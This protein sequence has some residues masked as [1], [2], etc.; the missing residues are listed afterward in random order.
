MNIEDL[1]P[2]TR[3]HHSA[4]YHDVSIMKTVVASGKCTQPRCKCVMYDFDISLMQDR[5]Q[6]ELTETL[7]A[8][9][10]DILKEREKSWGN[11]EETHARIAKI[12]SG[13]LDTEVTAYQVALCM[14][15]MKLVR[16]EKNP[17]EPDSLIDVDGYNRIAQEIAKSNMEV[18]LEELQN[19]NLSIV[20]NPGQPPID[21]AGHH[22]IQGDN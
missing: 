7:G 19:P 17:S 18:Y 12:W 9:D 3:C 14:M 4:A 5:L 13:I 15:G 1:A 20:R 8:A 16:A 2:C 10:P 6:A 11:A 21:Y 22:S